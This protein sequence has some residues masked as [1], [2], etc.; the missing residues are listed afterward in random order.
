MKKF[1]INIIPVKK[2]RHRL[3]KKYLPYIDTRPAHIIKMY[4]EN[5]ICETACLAYPENIELGGGTYIGINCRF[6]AEGG[7]KIGSDTFIGE[8]TLILTTIHNYKSQDCVPF[9]N[10]GIL[11]RV[12]VGNNVWIGARA[13]ITGGVKIEDGAIIAAGA[14]VTKSV[15]KCAI[16]GGNPAKIIGWRDVALYDKLSS[17][18]KVF[19]KLKN[20]ETKWVKEIGFKKFLTA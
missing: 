5:T 14:V 11:R 8:S 18:N 16:V 12:E 6:Y 9:D 1:L 3:R 10:I 2:I 13:I 15:P 17:E 4:S 20:K 7:L 19:S